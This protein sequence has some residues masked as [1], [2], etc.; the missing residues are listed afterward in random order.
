MGRVL[1]L[2]VG[3]L[4]TFDG[5]LGLAAPR[6]WEELWRG[7]GAFFPGATAEYFS[8]VMEVTEHYRE[9]SPQGLRLMQARAGAA[10]VLVL[11]SARRD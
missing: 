10:G 7:V 3:G 11:L 6:K 1:A 5:A 4:M 8:E 9:Q 2:L